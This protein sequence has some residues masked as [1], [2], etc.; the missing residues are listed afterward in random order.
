MERVSRRCPQQRKGPRRS[1]CSTRPKA[2]GTWW[3]ARHDWD[4]IPFG[5]VEG[6]GLSDPSKLT[7]EYGWSVDLLVQR[8]V[9]LGV[10]CALLFSGIWLWGVVSHARA[11]R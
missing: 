1:S 6:V 2:F 9:M 7:D 5:E 10:V 3:A 4:A 8:Y 11:T